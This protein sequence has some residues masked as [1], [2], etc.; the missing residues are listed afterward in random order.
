MS[1]RTDEVSAF[2]PPSAA[3]VPA[4]RLMK[5]SRRRSLAHADAEAA[6]RL[7]QQRIAPVDG[8]QRGG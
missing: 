5:Q 3:A 8:I 1:R 7:D 4:D 6:S 2:T